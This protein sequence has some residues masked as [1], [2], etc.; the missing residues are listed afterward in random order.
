MEKVVTNCPQMEWLP[1]LFPLSTA[2]YDLNQAH[3][4]L[5]CTKR[6]SLLLPFPLSLWVSSWEGKLGVCV[7][8]SSSF[9][10]FWHGLSRVLTVNRHPAAGLARPTPV[11][12]HPF[13]PPPLLLRN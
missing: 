13:P 10:L 6:F 2:S 4:F 3:C 9:P 7:S 1:S 5:N 12:S 11:V 8:P